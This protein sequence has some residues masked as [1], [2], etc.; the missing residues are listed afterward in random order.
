MERDIPNAGL[1]TLHTRTL[2]EHTVALSE[3][4]NRRLLE[5]ICTRLNLATIPRYPTPGMRP[6][7]ERSPRSSS[8]GPPPATT[9]PCNA[10]T[11]W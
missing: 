3:Q 4:Y 9:P 7:M 5:E 1:H 10:W 6:V 2:L 8:T 11:N